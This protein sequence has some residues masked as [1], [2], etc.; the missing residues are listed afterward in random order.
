MEW[1]GRRQ[2]W[3]SVEVEVEIVG[4]TDRWVSGSRYRTTLGQY[5]SGVEWRD[6]RGLQRAI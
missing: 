4:R 5:V 1:N 6:T 2:D 3:Q